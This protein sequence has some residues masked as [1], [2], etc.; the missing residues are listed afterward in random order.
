MF[1]DIRKNEFQFYIEILPILAYKDTH[2][3]IVE[4]HI[5]PLNFF[6]KRCL[7]Y[8]FIIY[9]V[10]AKKVGFLLFIKD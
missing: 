1:V 6:I 8:P 3:L 2:L 9:L 7:V 4:R 5:V 10:K